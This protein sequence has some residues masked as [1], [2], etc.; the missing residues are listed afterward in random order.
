MYAIL[1]RL[2]ALPEMRGSHF[3]ISL[4]QHALSYATSKGARIVSIGIIAEHAE[5]KSN[6]HSAH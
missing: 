1:E 4:V 5:F 2:C 6:T 3:D